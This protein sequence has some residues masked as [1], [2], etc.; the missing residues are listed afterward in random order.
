MTAAATDPFGLESTVL[1]GKYEVGEVLAEGGF[2]V[3]YR[4]RHRIWKKPIAIKVLKGVS[5][6]DS[7]VA[8]A[9]RDAF[10]Q[11]GALLGEL[12]TRST[13]VVQAWDVGTHTTERGEWLPYM[14]LEWLD[15]ES[16]EAI[17]VREPGRRWSLHDAMGLLGPVARALDIAHRRGIAHRDVKPE[18]LFVVM[19]GDE[20]CVKLLDFGIAKVM[21]TGALRATLATTGGAIRSFTPTYGAPEQFSTSFGATGPWTDVF[22]LALCMVELLSGHRALDGEEVVEL[23]QS[24]SDVLVRPTPRTRG[25]VVSD[26]V[27][28]VFRTALAVDPRKRHATAGELWDALDAA[29]RIAERPTLSPP[30]PSDPTPISL[31][32]PSAPKTVRRHGGRAATAALALGVIASGS[33][34]FAFLTRAQPAKAALD[35]GAAPLATIAGEAARTLCPQGSVRI[36]AGQFFMGSDAQD[37]LPNE[38]PSHNVKLDAFCM[39]LTEVTVRSYLACSNTGKC[40]RP[41]TSV[42]WPKISDDEKRVYGPLC[43]A[44]DPDARADHPIN[45]VDH[46]MAARYCEVAGGRLPTEA[47]WEYAARGPDGRIYPWG[48]EDPTAKHLNACGSEC[49]AWGKAHGQHLGELFAASD[50]YATTAPVG[51]FPAGRSRF[52]PLDVV[53]N[54][55]EWVA[56][57]YGSYGPGDLV[58]PRGPDHGERRVIRGGGWNGS[59]KSWLRPSFRYAQDP[60]ALSAGIGFRCVY[61][62]P[63]SA[64]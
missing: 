27:E 22:A 6:F 44:N 2:S 14:V 48:D 60:D 54:V 5:D 50:G 8:E 45:C 29:L 7:S 39:D 1:A 9:L 17:L 37:A 12:S 10:V 62:L 58:S 59:D 31:A 56:D 24:S 4:G 40:K 28:H 23:A 52:G 15:G 64:N 25:A 30:P 42:A 16:L 3:V 53:G 11:E 33:V 55:W 61:D 26:A 35:R 41:G 18:N 32:E 47:E 63:R 21:Q 19:R 36:P 13:A 38:K 46:E 43:N 20:L 57:W 49:V 34:G 51:R